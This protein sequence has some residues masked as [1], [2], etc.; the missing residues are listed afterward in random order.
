MFIKNLRKHF[1]IIFW[2]IA[3]LI[4]P[5]FV[6]WGIGSAIRS[7][8]LSYV[9]KIFG[10]KIYYEEF[11][12]TLDWLVVSKYADNVHNIHKYPTIYEDAW[13]RLILLEE[14]KK[15]KVAVSNQELASYI[16]LMP[17]F[18]RNNMFDSATYKYLLAYQFG[19]DSKVF[20]EEARKTLMIA[21]LQQKVFSDYNPTKDEIKK[22]YLRLNQSVKVE[23]IIFPLD[24]FKNMVSVQNT[25]I[26]RYYNENK[27]S[28]KKP[29]Q[30]NV[31]YIRVMIKPFEEGIEPKEE[32]IKTYYETHKE[33]FEIKTPPSED[34]QIESAQKEG[35]EAAKKE[36]SKTQKAYRSLED[37][38][39][40]IRKRL[41]MEEADKK[42]YKLIDSVSEALIDEPDMKK[43]ADRFNLRL[44][45]TGFF[46]NDEPLKEIGALKEFSS[47]AFNLK[48][49]EISQTLKIR[50]SYY[51]L[52]LKSRRKPHIAT[53]E[54]VKDQIRDTLITD[55]AHIFAKESSI[56]YLS[57]IKEILKNSQIDFREAVNS[58]GL[59][60]NG[61]NFVTRD[62]LIPKV[63]ISEEFL[64]TAF[65]LEPGQISEPVKIASGYS[66]IR[67]LDK[68]IPNEETFQKEKDKFSEEIIFKKKLAYLKEW[69]EELI[70][71]A[72]LES[73]IENVK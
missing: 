36:L 46:S 47:A 73:N 59:E 2:V 4:V 20:E 8:S 23:Y 37:A 32:E 50:D 31:E 71:K 42:A 21:K 68:K 1:K 45:E 15:S 70:E 72:N 39:Y 54:E 62:S 9:G 58:L 10:K 18:H 22:E 7:R 66:I 48:E 60:V 24:N 3:A 63:G 40:Y 16:M 41:I 29:E 57:K 17:Y 6:F 5:A 30:V 53:L 65:G 12:K 33:E 43:A 35:V 38:S 52:K 28:F 67:V 49:E 55:K 44:S 19:I 56:S 69:E 14:A 13:R 34:I 61:T 51:I 64:D 27:T 25:A 11:K 26:E